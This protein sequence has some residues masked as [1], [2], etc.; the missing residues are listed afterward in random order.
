MV[1]VLLYA[2]VWL[3][4]SVC[5]CEIVMDIAT[6]IYRMRVCYIFKHLTFVLVQ[7]AKRATLH[8]CSARGLAWLLIICKQ[9]HCCCCRCHDCDCCCCCRVECLLLS[10]LP[11]RAICILINVAAT[12]NKWKWNLKLKIIY[13]FHLLTTFYV[14]IIIHHHWSYFPV[15]NLKWDIH[16]DILIWENFLCHFS[17]LFCLHIA[18][19]TQSGSLWLCPIW[20]HFKWSAIGDQW[21]GSPPGTVQGKYHC[22][23]RF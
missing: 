2:C 22:Q 19:I 18:V 21:S 5:V 4:V 1:I 14:F 7:Q 6:Y 8:V 11:M 15:R 16:A 10:E 20:N 23:M 13:V 17:T 9:Q 12:C 3:C